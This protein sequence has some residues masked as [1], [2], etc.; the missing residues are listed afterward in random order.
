MNVFCA[1]NTP[2]LVPHPRAVPRIS[3]AAWER[4]QWSLGIGKYKGRGR[5]AHLA[6]VAPG[7]QVNLPKVP[8]GFT[9][10]VAWYRKHLK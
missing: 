2:M 4:A 10:A 6:S 3:K 5:A 8:K 7:E 1:P 9:R